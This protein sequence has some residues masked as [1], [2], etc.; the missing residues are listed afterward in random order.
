MPTQLQASVRCR[1]ATAVHYNSAP[2]YNP[3]KTHTYSTAISTTCTVHWT[4]VTVHRTADGAHGGLMA[5]SWPACM[6]G[7]S[8]MHAGVLAEA[9]G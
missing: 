1:G 6:Q 9:L 4:A 3:Q 5:G 2:D 7:D 8:N